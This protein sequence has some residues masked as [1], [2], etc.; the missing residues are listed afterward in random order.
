MRSE[1]EY[2]AA[3]KRTTIGIAV[4]IVGSLILA[5]W[6]Y[7]KTSPDGTDIITVAFSA[8]G[9][10]LLGGTREG[11]AYLWNF[12]DGRVLGHGNVEKSS[13]D[14]APAPFNSLALAPKGQFVVFAG[15]TLS[16][17]TIGSDQPAPMICVP[18]FAFGGAAV[19][20][21]GSRIS[22]VSSEEKLLVW[23]PHYATEPNDL[24]QADAGVYGATAFS[25]D[26]QRVISAG[27]T[28]RMIDADGAKE[29][30][31]RPRDNYAFL[32]VAF[33]PDGKLIATGSQDTSIRLWNAAS[34]YEV[35][36]LRGHGGYVD[37]VAF[38]PN[39]S[40][41]VSWARDGQLIL[42][43]I[44]AAKPSHKIL[45]VTKGGAAFSPD[46]RWIASGGQKKV[47][48]LWDASTGMETRKLSGDA[49]IPLP[50]DDSTGNHP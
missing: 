29:Q 42:W 23:K 33:S 20:P 14:H 12:G 43:D 39:G 31:R 49:P 34:G 2:P 6:P 38:S 1:Q 36:I 45:G 26:G 28:L 41:I 48:R 40:N 16:L 11:V 50:I 47:V 37:A 24:G 8:D 5:F 19:S 32:T 25:P 21:D 10:R 27:H 18:N 46:G 44:S 7:H 17:D 22:A 4:G 9:E 3:S 30:W 13:T 35:A 15:N